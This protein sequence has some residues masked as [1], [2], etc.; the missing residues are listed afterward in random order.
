MF[1]EI[2]SEYLSTVSV[3][4]D[5]SLA[6]LLLVLFIGASLT[7]PSAGW[8]ISKKNKDNKK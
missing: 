4:V 1:F 3:I 7:A 2:V 8:E 5:A 6:E